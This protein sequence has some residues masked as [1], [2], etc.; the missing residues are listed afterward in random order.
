M[1]RA[2]A[3]R[4]GAGGVVALLLLL[5]G[6]ADAGAQTGYELTLASGT[7]VRIT[8]VAEPGRRI[9]SE[10]LRVS[11]DTLFLRFA[12]P[13]GR[14]AYPLA[15]LR[16]LEVRGGLARWRGTLIGAAAGVAAGVALGGEERGSTTTGMALIGAS[17]GFAFAPRGWQ[18]L[19]LPSR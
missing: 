10:A 8:T 18:R 17:F 14:V 12:G 7:P 4:A 1:S 2:V 15:T 13:D 9:R 6:N 19:P 16:S 11:T 3:S 5:V